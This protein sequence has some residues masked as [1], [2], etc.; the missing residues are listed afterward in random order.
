MNKQELLDKYRYWEVEHDDWYGYTYEQ[1]I[2]RMETKGIFLSADDI[3][4]SGFCSQGDGASFTCWITSTKGFDV[5]C[6]EHGIYDE[7]PILQLAF[8]AGVDPT[9]ELIRGN[10]SH[11]CHEFTVY[12]QLMIE[13]SFLNCVPY[14]VNEGEP[15]WVIA[16]AL[17][18]EMGTV[19]TRDHEW[20]GF[21][22][23]VND[24]VRGYMKELYNELSDTYYDLISDD[25]VW[26]AIIN[27]ELDEELEDEAMAS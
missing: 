26:Q 7:Y 16:E 8:A 2:E 23:M 6:K 3:T 1:F 11:Y 10:N 22:R 27:N 12:A 4:F 21:E 15:K 24:I 5:F 17:D 9:I 20:D 25:V 13:N 14:Q 18:A 19:F